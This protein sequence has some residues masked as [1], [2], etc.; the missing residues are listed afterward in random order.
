M[1]KKKGNKNKELNEPLVPYVITEGKQVRIF[2]SFE[3]QEEYQLRQMAALS[4][5]QCL[6]YLRKMINLAYGM[7]GYDP[8]KLPTKHKL[9]FRTPP[10]F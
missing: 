10:I 7:H 5:I 4:P 3:E 9:R 6:E 8:D 2:K 1:T